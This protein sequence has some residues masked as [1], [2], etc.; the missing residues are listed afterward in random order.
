MTDAARHADAPVLIVGGSMGALRT[1]ESLRKAGYAGAIRVLG[2]EPHAPYNRP[3]L[4]KEVLAADVTHDAVAF[5]PR[6]STADVDWRFG[7]RAVDLDLDAAAVRTADGE[8]HR[9]RAL[10]IATGLRPRRLPVAPLPGRHVLRALDDAIALRSELVPGARV[11]VVGSGFVGC[12]VAATATKL[13]CQVTIVAPG[14][15]PLVTALG[16]P[17][18]GEVRRR[19]ELHGVR[20]L[21]GRTVVDLTGADWVESVVLDDG[22]VLPAD[23]VVEA[24][25]SVVN[26]EWLSGSGLDTADGVL[27]DGA[28][29]AVRAD[30][31]VL[32]DVY[33]VGDIARFPNPLFDDVPRRI[34]H[35]NIPTDTGRRAGA[36]LGA[37]LADDGSYQTVAATPFTPMPSFWSIQF[38]LS[39]QAYGMPSLA[40]PDGVRI[41]DGDLA[42]DVIV[43]YHRGDRLVGV[44]GLG[45]KGP[46]VPYRERIATGD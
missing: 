6:P 33:V 19:H 26:D 44:V 42:G 36:V 15:E 37:R 41:L 20:F 46:L 28:L 10:V 39:L 40:D 30:G 3:P 45:P 14:T 2:D 17:I 11:V 8:T 21:L 27:T 32:D 12:E 24:I 16:E 4:S 18:A 25:G 13:G 5:P 7:A 9:Y 43:G 35:W 23:V 22:T 1:A 38:D 31:T 34:E 29:R